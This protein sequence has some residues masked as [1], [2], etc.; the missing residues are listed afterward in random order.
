MGAGTDWA[1]VATDYLATQAPEDDVANV[2]RRLSEIHPLEINEGLD[3]DRA[4]EAKPHATAFLLFAIRQAVVDHALSDEEVLT[5][6]HLARVLRVQE[7][8]LLNRH[9][10]DVREL[11]CQELERLL[12][13]R[14]I[15]PAE[16]VHKVKLQEVLGLGY[17]QFVALTSPVIEK[18]IIDLIDELEPDPI[19][20]LT[21]SDIRLFHQ[22]LAALD[23]IYDLNARTT[24]TGGRGGY[25][26]LLLN[27]SMPGLIKVGRTARVPDQ[28]V[29]E[30]TN[31]T[32]VPTPFIL[33]YDVFVSDAEVAEK[34]VHA[35]L[36]QLGLRVADN[37]EFFKASPSMA[38]TV[39][40]EAREFSGK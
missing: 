4:V 37:R 27:P 6:R 21:E 7:G 31:A 2:L 40:L 20:G 15:D 39:M 34:Y 24:A 5:L 28:R 1:Q 30:L 9:R 8:D 14:A 18:V 29:A 32:G 16:A 25:L 33:V 26:Y 36:E 19:L 22:R 35:K 3:P 13:D 17:D 38:V 12:E 10:E 23:S 11:L